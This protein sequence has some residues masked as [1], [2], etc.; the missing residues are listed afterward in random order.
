MAACFASAIALS[1]GTWWYSMRAG[2]SA[3]NRMDRA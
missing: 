1:L 3:L 2:I